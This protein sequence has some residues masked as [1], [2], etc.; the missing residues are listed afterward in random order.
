MTIC[1]ASSAFSKAH[2]HGGKFLQQR[3]AAIDFLW[4]GGGVG[5]FLMLDIFCKSFEKKYHAKT[6]KL[7][8]IP[9]SHL[10]SAG[11][12]SVFLHDIFFFQTFKIPKALSTSCSGYLKP[13]ISVLR[14][15]D[16]RLGE[17]DCSA[18]LQNL[19]D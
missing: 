3:G 10:C 5:E 11:F 6:L 19:P 8:K 14:S 17:R 9:Q 12:V 15:K 1:C 13:C 2:L 16:R 18:F 7:K 4:G